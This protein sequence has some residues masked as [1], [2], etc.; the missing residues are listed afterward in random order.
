MNKF[1]A[2]NLKKLN[3][4]L[5]VLKQKNVNLPQ[6]D[7]LKIFDQ[8]GIKFKTIRLI[9]DIKDVNI[10]KSDFVLIYG[11]ERFLKDSS[12]K[13]KRQEIIYDDFSNWFC[14]DLRVYNIA[15]MGYQEYIDICDNKIRIFKEAQ[16]SDVHHYRDDDHGFVG[17]EFLS[18]LKSLQQKSVDV[19]EHCGKQHD[20]NI[21]RFS[22]GIKKQAGGQ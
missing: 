2:S 3:G 4:S 13:L 1:I 16:N 8:Y 15:L 18:D 7:C 10:G 21:D 20:Q 17:P 9:E 6:V 14:N 22:P 11:D 5:F 12:V 19:I